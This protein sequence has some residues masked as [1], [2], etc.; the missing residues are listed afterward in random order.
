MGRVVVQLC[1]RKRCG[2]LATAW[3]RRSWEGFK[4]YTQTRIEAACKNHRAEGE[5]IEEIEQ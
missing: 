2:L 4:G 1:Q 3:I 5:V